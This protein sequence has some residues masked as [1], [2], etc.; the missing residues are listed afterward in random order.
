MT[1]NG[2]GMNAAS[3]DF[4]QTP[5]SMMASAFDVPVDKVGLFKLEMQLTKAQACMPASQLQD[6]LR[7]GL[8]DMLDDTAST[9]KTVQVISLSVD[10]GDEVC[11][12]TR[13]SIRKLLGL[14]SATATINMLVVFKEGANANFDMVEFAKKQGV[15][16]VQPA[17]SNAKI[18][19]ETMD[20]TGDNCG[21]ED[22]SDKSESSSSNTGLIAG[23][24]GGVVGA[25]LVAIGAVFWMR[26][27]RQETTT[28]AAVQSIN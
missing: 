11:P 5:Q 3:M 28:V 19:Y 23:V 10:K 6:S 16:S 8:K 1:D 24:A 25:L 26:S 14:S 9:Y 12:G 22:S 20:C 4:Q 17:E 13:R 18:T 7:V 27:R 2:A 21:E 15:N